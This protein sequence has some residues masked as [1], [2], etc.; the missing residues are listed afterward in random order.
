MK[1]LSHKN[2]DSGLWQSNYEYHNY[3]S[4]ILS[5]PSWT[6][7]SFTDTLTQI[8]NNNSIEIDQYDDTKDGYYLIHYG[9][10]SAMLENYGMGFLTPTMIEKCN[11]G[12][13]KLLVVYVWETLDSMGPSLKEWFWNFCGLITRL[14]ITRSDSVTI[15][16]STA[17]SRHPH[18]DNRCKFVYYPWFEAAFQL[19]LKQEHI[20]PNPTLCQPGDFSKK[21][22]LFINLNLS[23]RPH[24]FVMILYLMYLKL[25]HFGHVS[26]LNPNNLSWDEILNILPEHNRFGWQ[27]QLGKHLPEFLYFIKQTKILKSMSLD[28]LQMNQAHAAAWRGAGEFYQ[29]AWVDLVSETHCELYGDVFLTEKTFKPMAY[30]LPFIFNASENH[31]HQVRQLGYLSFPELFGEHYDTM[32]SGVEKIQE[33]ANQVYMLRADPA[34][35]ILL[36]HAE[37][38]REKIIHNYNLFW[39][40]NHAYQLSKLLHDAWIEG[41]A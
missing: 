40:K 10:P 35:L 34:K 21:D 6:T 36:K 9:L 30:G 12:S 13:L 38:I 1:I 39:G 16:T 2:L 15:L 28:N 19:N 33:I 4:P 11:Q 20:E 26:W 3:M 32:P 22:K 29:T 14:G 27:A 18:H 23:I 8:C 7:S 17:I 37:N 31:L 25:D 41:R 24:R 5:R